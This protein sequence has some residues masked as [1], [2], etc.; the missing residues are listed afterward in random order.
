M[1]LKTAQQ[2]LSELKQQLEFENIDID[3][4]TKEALSI[5]DMSIN[6]MRV[7]EGLIRTNCS[8]DK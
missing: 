2:K 4:D 5:A 7:A 1:D 8:S 6:Y 3:D